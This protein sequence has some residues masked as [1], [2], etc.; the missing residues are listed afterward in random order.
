MCW[1]VDL[2]HEHTIGSRCSGLASLLDLL[3]LVRVI[4]VDLTSPTRQGDL[5]SK[6]PANEVLDVIQSIFDANSDLHGKL[7]Q[8]EGDRCCLEEL[9][10]LDDEPVVEDVEN[11]HDKPFVGDVGGEGRSLHDDQKSTK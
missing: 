5:K 1:F 2:V 11:S 8:E 6:V 4:Q 10:G 3:L 7:L 9:N